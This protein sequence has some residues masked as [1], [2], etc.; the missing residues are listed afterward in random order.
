ME[1]TVDVINYTDA[2]QNL[3]DV[4]DRVVADM[5]PVVVTRQKADAVVMISLAQWNSIEATLHLLSSPRNA[6]RLH[7]AIQQLDAGHGTERELIEDEEL[8]AAE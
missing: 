4:M 3:K 2:R 5:S 6:E 7:E 8:I 1:A